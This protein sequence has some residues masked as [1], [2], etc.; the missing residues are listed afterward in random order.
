M[1]ATWGDRGRGRVNT[2][3]RG[4]LYLS[5][6]PGPDWQRQTVPDLS[7]PATVGAVVGLLR[8]LYNEPTLYLGMWAGRWCILCHDERQLGYCQWLTLSGPRRWT[9][10]LARP[11]VSGETEAEALTI[12]L[13]TAP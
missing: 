2:D 5:P 10:N 1:A 6:S 7:D 8:E 13:E 3:I 9:P 4:D 11:V 12:A